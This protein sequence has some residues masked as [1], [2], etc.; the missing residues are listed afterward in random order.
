MKLSAL[1]FVL[2]LVVLS[3]GSAGAGPW[4]TL[5]APSIPRWYPGCAV[6]D[7]DIYLIGGQDSIPPFSSIAE[8][9]VYDTSIDTWRIVAPLNHDRWGMA[10]SVVNGRIYVIGGQTGSFL[11]GYTS[12]NF[13]EV[14]DPETDSWTDLSPMPSARGWTGSAVYDDTIIVFGGYDPENEATGMEVEKYFP[15]T[16]TWSSD[17]AMSDYRETF[18]CISMNGLIYLIGGWSNELVEVY[19]PVLKSWTELAPLPTGRGGSGICILGECICVVGGR[20]GPSAVEAYCPSTDSWMTMDS[21]P[22]PREGL[23]A[24]FVNGRLYAIT[25]SAP[26][27][28]GGLPYYGTNECLDLQSS[29]ED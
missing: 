25:G 18:S 2:I 20:G 9:E 1:V 24:A 4:S 26:V 17:P 13:V 15:A 5:A 19:D 22:T 23:V 28:E 7:D 14:Y 3:V 12:T 27:A 29:C 8:V 6:I 10:V 11:D 16:D 21:L